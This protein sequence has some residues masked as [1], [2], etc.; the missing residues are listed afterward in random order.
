M[1]IYTNDSLFLVP[2]DG[3][4]NIVDEVIQRHTCGRR[5]DDNRGGSDFYRIKPM[6]A[7]ATIH[8]FKYISFEELFRFDSDLTNTVDYTI[9][10]KITIQLHG[11]SQEEQDSLYQIIKHLEI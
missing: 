5:A 9:A 10:Q 4:S 1:C 3:K 7:T 6:T 11:R 2:C 8:I